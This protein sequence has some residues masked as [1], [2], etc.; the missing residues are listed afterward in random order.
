MLNMSCLTPI[1]NRYG[2]YLKFFD[3][4]NKHVDTNNPMNTNFRLKKIRKKKLIYV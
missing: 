1:I 3:T 2:L 4:I